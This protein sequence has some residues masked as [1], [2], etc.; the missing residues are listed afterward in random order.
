M[1]TKNLKLKKMMLCQW[2]QVQMMLVLSDCIKKTL[3]DGGKNDTFDMILFD[4]TFDTFRCKFGEED[5]SDKENEQI[6]RYW[7][8]SS[9]IPR[10]SYECFDEGRETVHN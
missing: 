3:F 8:D 7:E 6:F 2:L 10:I 1:C 4:D 5:F 9:A